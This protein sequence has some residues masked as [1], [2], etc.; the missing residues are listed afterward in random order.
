MTLR[1]SGAWLRASQRH[2]ALRYKK[3]AAISSAVS[4]PRA[5]G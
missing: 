5:Q 2:R 4:L 3:G 1:P